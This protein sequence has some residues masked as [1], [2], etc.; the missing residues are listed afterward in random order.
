MT[1]RSRYRDARGRV[2]GAVI[3]G[4]HASV[5]EDSVD[6][7]GGVDWAFVDRVVAHKV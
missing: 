3:S 5:Q 4:L 6:L 2:A 1:G 7:W